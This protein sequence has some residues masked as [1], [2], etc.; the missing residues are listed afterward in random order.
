[1]WSLFI[2]KVAPQ[3]KGERVSSNRTLNINSRDDRADGRESVYV[4]ENGVQNRW[5]LVRLRDGA[6]RLARRVGFVVRVP[7]PISKLVLGIDL[8]F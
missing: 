1:M 5:P 8:F 7:K 4:P 2:G 6:T 3:L